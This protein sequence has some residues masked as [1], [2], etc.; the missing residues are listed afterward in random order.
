MCEICYSGFQRT[1]EEGE[2]Q[3][4]GRPAGICYGCWLQ[5][6]KTFTSQISYKVGSEI[7]SPFE[8]RE[9]IDVG[10][11]I[12]TL[13]PPHQQELHEFLFKK[14]SSFTADIE[15]CPSE[16]CDYVFTVEA[17]RWGKG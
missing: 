4:E 8:G 17:C 14:Y 16:A 6:I 15:K 1:E 9:P 2:G 10:V 3:R 12:R 13:L 7:I 11:A 5:H